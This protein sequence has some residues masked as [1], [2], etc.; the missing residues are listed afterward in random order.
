VGNTRITF[1]REN[2]RAAR[3]RADFGSGF[4]TFTR[5]P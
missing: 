1:V 4:S 5:V 2:G 3:V